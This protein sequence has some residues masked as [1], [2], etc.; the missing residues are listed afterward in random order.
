MKHEVE[1]LKPLFLNFSNEQHNGHCSKIRILIVDDQKS[2]RE[3]LQF[4]LDSRY[5][6]RWLDSHKA[7]RVFATRY[8]AN[9]SENAW[10]GWC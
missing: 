3:Q 7:V 9:R 6:R 2:V 1:K 10:N 5:G 4:I 8:F